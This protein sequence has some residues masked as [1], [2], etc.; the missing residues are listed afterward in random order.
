MT[1]KAVLISVLLV[2]STAVFAQGKDLHDA[3]C[4]QCHASLTAG[5]PDSLYTRPDRKISSLSA[6]KKQ[7]QGCSVAAD[8]NWTNAQH[9]AVVNYLAKTFYHF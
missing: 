5:K 8:T 2:V 3:S 1:I 7:V 9:E 6:L 4:L